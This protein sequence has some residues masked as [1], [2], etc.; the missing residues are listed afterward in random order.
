MTSSS[1]PAHASRSRPLRLAMA[2]LAPLVLAFLAPVGAAAA[3]DDRFPDLG[4]CQELGVE[5]GNEVSAYL[6]AVGTQNYRWNGQRWVFI[7]PE[8]MLFADAGYHGLV[9]LH[10]V[11]P[12]WQSVSGSQ[13]VGAL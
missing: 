10:F 12:T 2:S 13:V 11:G 4:E 5:D 7:A 3:G 1:S 6:Y 8:A 9:V